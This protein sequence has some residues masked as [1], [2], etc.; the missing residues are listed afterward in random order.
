M[1]QAVA[2]PL[3]LRISCE[4]CGADLLVEPHLKTAECPYCAS[5][6]IVERPAGGDQ[7]DPVFALGFVVGRER[8]RELCVNWIKSRGVFTPKSFKTALPERGRGLYMPAYLYCAVAHSEYTCKIG[9]NYTETYTTTDSKGRVVVRTRTRTEW[10]NLAGRSANYVRDILVTASAGI[11]NK[12]LEQ[13]EPFDLRALS[14]YTP[15]LLSGWIAEE[16]SIGREECRELARTESIEKIGDRLNRFMPGDSHTDLQH[17][18]WLEEEVTDLML[19]PIWVYAVKHADDK[20]PVQ[21]LV[22]GQTGEVAGFVPRSWARI[23]T[24]VLVT[25]LVATV[26]FFAIAAVVSF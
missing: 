14:R 4:N 18:T 24:V 3:T 19:L 12:L 22:N 7:V 23:L 25:L 10:R 20:E 26:V 16:A 21:I 8:A 11:S 6:S 5:T 1:N 13:V 2:Q 9:E 15:A 17:R